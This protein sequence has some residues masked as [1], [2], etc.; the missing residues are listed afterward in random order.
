MDQKL[1]S[2]FF[3]RGD[4]PGAIEYM[5]RYE[6]LNGEV[7][8]YRNLFEKEQ[9]LRY[10]IPEI[11]NDIL[12]EYQRYFRDVFYCCIA[13]ETASLQLFERLGN[14]FGISSSGSDIEERVKAI[15]E[16]QGYHVQTGK[17]GG[18][19]GPYIWKETVPATYD[20]EL[21]CGVRQ[22][23]VNILRGFIM[24]SWLDYL[25]FG[26]KGT[27]GWAGEDGVINCVEK[28]YDFESEG[29]H[30]SL[31][32]HEAQHVEDMARWPEMPP[33]ELEYRAKLVELIYSEDENL[34]RRFI[35]EAGKDKSGDSHAL[36]SAKI[37]EEMGDCAG[38]SINQIQ[39]R[40]KELFE[41]SSKF[42]R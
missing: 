2:S 41:I 36:A 22:Y 21:P 9:Y 3:F 38:K 39:Q 18:H 5:S 31:L 15:F 6:E 8:K 4:I 16:Q 33:A 11:L 34:L 24:R 14:R 26:K 37:A 13:E 25:T 30:V 27:G 19:Y 23:K 12:L 10:D 29:F 1:L 35:S 17:T 42:A 20:V 7:E 32:K 40:A 28:A